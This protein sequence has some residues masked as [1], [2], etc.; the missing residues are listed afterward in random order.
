MGQILELFKKG[1]SGEQI[2]IDF[3]SLAFILRNE[4]TDGE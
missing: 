3:E 2:T 4:C 1:G